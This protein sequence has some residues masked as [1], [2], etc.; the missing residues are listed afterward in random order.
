VYHVLRDVKTDIEPSTR[1][2]VHRMP[3]WLSI[4]VTWPHTS[5]KYFSR[6]L[7]KRIHRV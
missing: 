7:R 6:Y 4:D 1:L 5:R 2:S 3:N